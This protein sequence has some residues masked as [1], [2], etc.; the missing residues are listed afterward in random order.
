M[1]PMESFCAVALFYKVTT[2]TEISEYWTSVPRG[3]PQL[4]SYEPLVYVCF[5][6]KS[7]YL[8]YIVNLLTPNSQPIPQ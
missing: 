5:W 8:V 3:D 1:D 4:G 6:W 2:N 7:P